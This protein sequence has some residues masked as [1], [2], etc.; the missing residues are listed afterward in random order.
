MKIGMVGLGKMGGNMVQR[1]L[2]HGV[3][4]VAFDLN[5][6]NV[7][8]AVTGG[9]V[10]ASSLEELVSKLK[11]SR[12]A[13]WIMVPA[14]KPTQIT[15][16]TLASL[17]NQDDVL[18][19]GGNSNFKASM[20]RGSDLLAMGIQFVDVGT[21][22]GIWGLSEGYCMM[23]G[24]NEGV[25]DFLKPVFEALAPDKD[26][27][28][29]RMGPV[30]AG[31]YVKMI[32]NGIEYGMMQAYAEGFELMHA[33]K[34]FGLDISDIA[35]LWRHGSVVRS[36]LLDLTAEALKSDDDL[37][38]L[39]DYVADSGEGRW[40]VNDSIEQG[41]PAPVI[42]MSVQMRFRSQ[43]DESYAGKVLSAMRN[44]FGGHTVKTKV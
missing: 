20:A 39:D 25:V 16:D 33:K 13:I 37:T 44:A 4:V 22:G 18:I 26:R 43:Q 21:S 10:G 27:G 11:G 38:H 23:V 40:T 41:I 3:E 15:I 24:G 31:H 6:A 5:P 9:A 35:E 34:E 12:R 7:E 36:W 29:R 42:T 28:W 8:M 17:V 32:H 14:G 19:D 1:L 2:E 30:G